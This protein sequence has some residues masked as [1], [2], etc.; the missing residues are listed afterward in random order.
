MEYRKTT[1]AMDRVN[2]WSYL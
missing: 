2:Y 1:L